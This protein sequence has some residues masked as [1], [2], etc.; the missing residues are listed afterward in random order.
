MKKKDYDKITIAI[1]EY[2]S[3][4]A[5]IHKPSNVIK[6]EESDWCTHGDIAHDIANII[7]DIMKKKEGHGRN[8]R[9]NS[10]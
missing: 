5:I 4:F 3:E 10:G 9:N 7:E 2:L 6:K 1:E 8:K